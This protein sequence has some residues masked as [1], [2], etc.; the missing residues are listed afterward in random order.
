MENIVERSD[1]ELD[2][3]ARES[4]GSPWVTSLFFVDQNLHVHS[5]LS[6]GPSETLSLHSTCQGQFEVKTSNA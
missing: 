1:L 6:L 4:C 5:V 2:G 3:V